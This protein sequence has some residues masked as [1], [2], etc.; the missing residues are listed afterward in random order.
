[1]GRYG[2]VGRG[3][4]RQSADLAIARTMPVL[5]AL[6]SIVTPLVLRLSLDGPIPLETTA[7]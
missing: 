7:W 5:L 6:L 4:L 3:D 2:L 1:M